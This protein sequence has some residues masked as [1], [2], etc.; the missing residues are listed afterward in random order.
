MINFFDFAYYA[1][2][3]KVNTLITSENDK[4]SI[5]QQYSKFS[6]CIKQRQD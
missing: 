3:Q 1:K 5:F 6:L 2:L 4:K